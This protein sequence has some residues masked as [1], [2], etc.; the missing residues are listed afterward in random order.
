MK[1]DLCLATEYIAT[2]TLEEAM[3]Q[4]KAGK[5]RQGNGASRHGIEHAIFQRWPAQQRFAILTGLDEDLV[6]RVLLDAWL[7][8]GSCGRPRHATEEETLRVQEA[9][10][11]LI[12]QRPAPYRPYA[13]PATG[14]YTG[15]RAL[16][17]AMD[18]AELT[19]P[20]SSPADLFPPQN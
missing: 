10:R 7:H 6:R 8:G 11:V 20:L 14:E 18:G 17:Q 3:E 16:L 1:D 9:F 5:Y 15:T 12:Q 19:F 13:R 4:L 2:L